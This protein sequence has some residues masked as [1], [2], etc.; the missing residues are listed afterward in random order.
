MLLTFAGLNCGAVEIKVPYQPRSTIDGYL[1]YFLMHIPLSQTR[2]LDGNRIEIS[3]DIEVNL[4]RLPANVAGEVQA[5][6]EDAVA[7]RRTV[8]GAQLETSGARVTFA[9]ATAAIDPLADP[10]IHA[11]GG[12]PAEAPD[13]RVRIR[14]PGEDQAIV[15]E[16]QRLQALMGERPFG[17]FG[18]NQMLTNVPP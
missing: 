3:G 13:V 15:L 8:T 5:A 1:T 10:V 7:G 6:V 9:I 14:P 4:G 12:S 2:P 11:S 17:Q 18:C 16:A